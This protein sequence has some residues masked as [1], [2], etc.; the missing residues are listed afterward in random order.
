ML[1]MIPIFLAEDRVGKLRGGGG[2]FWG[3]TGVDIAEGIE[4]PRHVAVLYY[5]DVKKGARL[6]CLGTV[7][8]SK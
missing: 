2:D 7:M 6:S 4:M 8:H 1:E 5:C 3:K